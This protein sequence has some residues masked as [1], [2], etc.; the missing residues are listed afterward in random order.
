MAGMKVIVAWEE[1][2]LRTLRGGMPLKMALVKHKVR[3]PALNYA[4][5]TR[6]DFKRR[7]DEIF[8]QNQVDAFMNG[9]E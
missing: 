6:P 7:Y 3:M 5:R 9:D 2:L 1:D 4:L 8:T